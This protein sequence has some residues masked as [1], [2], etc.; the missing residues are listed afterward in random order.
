MASRTFGG[1]PVNPRVADAL[2][3]L[4]GVALVIAGWEL[5]ARSGMVSQAV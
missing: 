3:G 5:I 4:G 1:A 2:L